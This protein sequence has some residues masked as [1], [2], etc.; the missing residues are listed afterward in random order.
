M[1]HQSQR[2]RLLPRLAPVVLVALIL[3]APLAYVLAPHLKRW[4]YIHWLASQ[5]TLRRNRALSYV[6]AHAGEDERV[7]DGAIGQLSV[8]DDANFQQIVDAL[9]AVGRWSLADIPHDAWLRWVGLLAREPGV[10][11]PARAAQRL[12]SLT[13]LADDRRMIRLLTELLE[14]PEAD[15]R[16]NALCAAAELYQATKDTAIYD[17]LIRGRLEDVEPV[18]VHHAHIFAYLTDTPD[19]E[20][21]A[22]LR[23]LPEP[24]DE[25]RYDRQA[26]DNLLRSPEAALRDVGCVLAVRDLAPDNVDTLTA[27]LL[28]DPDPHAR[29]AGAVL[30]GVTGRQTDALR[31]SLAQQT[32]WITA[33]VMRLGLW[34]QGKDT[35]QAINPL[36][37]LARPDIPRTTLIFA[38]MHRN[39][40]L[41]LEALLSPQGEVPDDLARLLEDHGW[42]RVLNRYLSEDAPRWRPDTD[43][44]QQQRQIDLLRDWHLVNRHRLN[45]D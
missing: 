5:D 38:M 12:A 22:W 24:P 18:I 43:P 13:D 30:S 35:E 41:A 14:H 4:T 9:Q 45:N 23:S 34:M 32:D 42:W 16:Y 7:L 40:P 39:D 21:P 15:V 10:E 28:E 1:I 44:Q 17:N 27:E 11:A 20:S 36:S 2:R 3:S 37:L 6:A 31:H 25:P 19:T 29:M 33:T 8:E 26:I